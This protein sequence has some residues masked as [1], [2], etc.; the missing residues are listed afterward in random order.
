MRGEIASWY[1]RINLTARR[2]ASR[3]ALTAKDIDQFLTNRC[4]VEL[5]S[6]RTGNYVVVNRRKKLLMLPVKLTQHALNPI[7]YHGIADLTTDRDPQ[8]GRVMLL[9]SF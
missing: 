6:S 1:K 8:T 2:L 9:S 4:K 5:F 3:L 7:A